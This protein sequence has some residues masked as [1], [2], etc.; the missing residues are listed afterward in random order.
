MVYGEKTPEL[1]GFQRWVIRRADVG[2]NACSW[3]EFAAANY[4]P[5]NVGMR[6]NL[7]P[8]PLPVREVD[9]QNMSLRPAEVGAS[10]AISLQGRKPE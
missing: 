7:T 10:D 1:A 5:E 3:E 6:M 8:A 9:E 4:R 2:K